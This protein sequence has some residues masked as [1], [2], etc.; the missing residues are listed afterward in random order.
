MPESTPPL[1]L[2]DAVCQL[3]DRVIQHAP[4][5]IRALEACKSCGHEV[6]D[7]IDEV[8]RASE[9][10]AQVKRVFFPHCT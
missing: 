1:A 9:Y 8:R 5:A 4:A 2:P 6:Q 10:A 3:C 7:Q